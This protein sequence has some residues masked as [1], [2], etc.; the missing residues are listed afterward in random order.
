A[1]ALGIGTGLLMLIRE[2]LDPAPAGAVV[3]ISTTDPSVLHDLPAWRR[4][5]AHVSLGAASGPGGVVHDLRKGEFRST[6]AAAKDLTYS[7]DATAD[8]SCFANDRRLP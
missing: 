3:A 5:M 8:L 4:M 7:P 2:S 1:G 6:S